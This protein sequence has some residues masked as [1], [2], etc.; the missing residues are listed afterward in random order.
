MVTSFSMNLVNHARMQVSN[1]LK[2]VW[3]SAIPKTPAQMPGAIPNVVVMQ[4]TRPI[5]GLNAISASTAPKTLKNVCTNAALFAC[6][7]AS[8]AA[9]FAE[10]VVP[11]FSPSTIA[12]ASSKLIHP[13]LSITI[14]SV[15]APVDCIPNARI[16]PMAINIGTPRKLLV[17]SSEIR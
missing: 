5:S 2:S 1:R 16:H 3:K 10:I 17:W 13:Q 7:F 15:T 4:P 9:M 6:I 12:A 11:M 14:V 8:V